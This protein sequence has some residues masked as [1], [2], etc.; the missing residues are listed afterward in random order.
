MSG[1]ALRICMLTTFYPPYHF[2]GDAVLVQRLVRALE[3]RGHEVH[4]VHNLDAYRLLGGRH[5]DEPAPPH[6][7]RLRNR[8]PFSALLLSQQTGRPGLY[9]GRI[10]SI[11]QPGRFDVLHFHNVSLIG[12]PQVLSCGEGIKLYTAHEHWLICPTHALWKFNREP[13]RKKNCFTCTIHSRRPP[14]LWRYWP[15]IRGA[16][17]HLDALL[18]P[19]RF[20]LQRHRA[21]GIA[22]RLVHLPHF[23]PAVEQVAKDPAATPYFLVVGRLEKLKGVQTLIPLLAR[24]PGAELWIVGR[25]DYEEHLHRLARGVPSVR[26]LGHR[27]QEQ[28]QKLYRHAL[29]LIVPSLCEEVFGLV[30]L[31]AFAQATPVVARRRGSLTEIV[32][33]SGG[34][35][36]YSDRNDLLQA[37]NRLQNNPELRRELGAKGRQALSDRWSEETHVGAYLAL[38][39]ELER[40]G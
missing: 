17:G 34:G 1:R 22:A 39:A 15:G 26:F 33:E 37:L 10:E 27:S 32:E 29:A 2:G 30:M 20:T 5:P 19:S 9:S 21:E 18:C 14:Q 28:L 3:L 40:R 38:I 35:L 4:V 7:H 13:C 8:F 31:E 6:V 24:Y 16:L 12:G 36:L 11:L 23:L 25:G